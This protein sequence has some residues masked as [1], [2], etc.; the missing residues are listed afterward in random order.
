MNNYPAL[1]RGTGT[2]YVRYTLQSGPYKGSFVTTF[3]GNC[4]GG[5]VMDTEIFD[6]LDEIDIVRMK[7]DHLKLRYNEDCDGIDVDFLDD[8]GDLVCRIGADSFD[9]YELS[10]LVVAIE[11][12]SFVED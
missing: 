12:I 8:D 1:E 7:Y 5:S 9:S 4:K 6:L 3:K 2:H 11:I 10:R